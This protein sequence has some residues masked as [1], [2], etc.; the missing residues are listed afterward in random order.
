MSSERRGFQVKCVR[1]YPDGWELVTWW[2]GPDHGWGTTS[3]SRE[4]STVALF[5]SR[6]ATENALRTVFRTMAEAKRRGY[7]IV[8]IQE[9]EK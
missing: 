5:T 8:R 4:D 9:V 3:G 1:S 7:R 2:Y 6:L